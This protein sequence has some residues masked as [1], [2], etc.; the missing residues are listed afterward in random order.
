MWQLGELRARQLV[1]P[2][3]SLAVL[4]PAPPP[5]CYLCGSPQCV[6]SLSLA[7]PATTPMPWQGFDEKYLG[8]SREAAGDAAAPL[9]ELQFQEDGRVVP[10][11]TIPVVLRELEALSSEGPLPAPGPPAVDTGK[12]GKPR[13]QQ[14]PVVRGGGYKG[15]RGVG[16]GG[17][18]EAPRVNAHVLW[19]VLL[20]PG[21]CR[22]QG[23]SGASALLEFKNTPLPH[24][25]SRCLWVSALRGTCL[26]AP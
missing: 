10:S 12:G 23:T 19:L 25:C 26:T 13:G 2:W 7:P 8:E 9:M 20:V 21:P 1:A 14:R 18:L 22:Q 24:S 16:V 4:P 3:A 17:S 15:A 6:R 5:P 11:S